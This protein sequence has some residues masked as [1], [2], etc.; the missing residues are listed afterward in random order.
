MTSSFWLET[1]PVLSDFQPSDRWRI[2]GLWTSSFGSDLARPMLRTCQGDRNS[3]VWVLIVSTWWWTMRTTGQRRSGWE[4]SAVRVWMS[5][6]VFLPNLFVNCLTFLM[7]PWVPGSLRGWIPWIRSQDQ[8]ARFELYF[9]E[10]LRPGLRGWHLLPFWGGSRVLTRAMG[11]W[12]LIQC[13]VM[14]C[15][16]I[17][18]TRLSSAKTRPDLC[19]YSRLRGFWSI[20]RLRAVQTPTARMCVAT[21]FPCM[22]SC[23]CKVYPHLKLIEASLAV[24]HHI[25]TVRRHCTAGLLHCKDWSYIVVWNS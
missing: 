17:V 3:S 14:W 18:F 8:I 24:W 13:D 12:E 11:Q 20:P 1:S 23:C 22:F 10:L 25:S 16:S 21:P 2:T 19:R 15:E 6:F 5:F 9:P 7:G 4:N